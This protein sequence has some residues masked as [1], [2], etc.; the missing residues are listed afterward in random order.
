MKSMT[1]FSSAQA[2][3][4]LG[5]VRADI[6]SVNQKGLDIQMRTPRACAAFEGDLEKLAKSNL[7]RGKVFISLHLDLAS[8][9]QAS[10][11]LDTNAAQQVIQQLR[12]TAKENGLQDDLR[13]G[14]L[15][16]LSALWALQNKDIDE[17][18]LKVLATEATQKALDGLNAA[19]GEEGKGL[20]TIITGHLSHIKNLVAEIAQRQANFPQQQLQIHRERL[21]TLLADT[22]INEERILQEASH[23]ADRLDISEEV[24]RLN[25]HIDHVHTLMGESPVGRK[26][27]F[28]CQEFIREAN[29]VGSK[30]NQT[31]VAHLV[32]ELKAEVE[33]MREQVQNVE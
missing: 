24:N 6:K 31:A 5:V 10:L 29:T 25:L 21:A 33:K 11:Q 20:K 27:D 17:N 19:R 16:H 18:Q 22:P 14:D 1:G 4:D 9:S 13:N 28:M 15:V 2:N 7:R 26:L 3:G 23:M 32:V 12:A 8:E 30:C